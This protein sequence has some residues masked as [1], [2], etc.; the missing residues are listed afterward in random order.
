MSNL[1]NVE[2]ERH[3]FAS[4]I[5]NPEQWGEV[6]G[7]TTAQDFSSIHQ[8]IFNVF[9]LQLDQTPAKPIQPVI[10][11]DVIKQHSIPLDGITP[12]EYLQS[13]ELIPV[14][15]DSC[16]DFAKEIK[17]LSVR[18]D[19]IAKCDAVKSDLMRNKDKSVGDMLGLVEKELNDV[20]IKYVEQ[21]NQEIFSS[22]IEVIEEKGN[23]PQDLTTFGLMGP[24][25]S[26]NKTLGSLSYPSAF[27][28][29]G[30]R[31]GNGK[32]SLGFHYNTFVAEKYEI[33]VLHLDAGEMTVE[34][35]Q[36]R[37]TA[38]LSNGR[39]PLNMIETGTWRKNKEFVNIIRGE[40]WPRVKKIKTYYKNISGMTPKEFVSYIRRFYFSKIGRGNHLLIHW[41]YIKGLEAVAG[42]NSQEYQSIGYMVG[43][44]K[45]L[46]TTEITASVWTSV[47]NNKQG[48]YNG[49]DSSQVVDNE[50]SLSLSDRIL[51]QSTNAFTMRYKL[52]D[53][54]AKEGNLFGNVMLKSLKERKLLGENFQEMLDYVK[55]IE[56]DRD[57]KQSIKY[58]KNYFNLESKSFCYFDRG[59]LKDM[60]T[61][62]ARIP[63]AITNKRNYK[64]EPNTNSLQYHIDAPI[65]KCVVG[66]NLLGIKTG[67]SCCGFSYKGEEVEK[68][69]LAKSYIYI[70]NDLSPY[71]AKLLLDLAAM[72]QLTIDCIMGG[73][74]DFYGKTWHENH[75]WADLKCPHYYESFVL[76]INALEKA[77]EAKKHL[78]FDECIIKDGNSLYKDKFKIKYWQ[79]EPA[80]DWI[81]K[82][83]EWD[84]L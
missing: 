47:Q 81:L 52:P 42:K 58:K 7:F 23:N 38:S 68:K 44:L 53:E 74:I 29:V 10:L 28:T 36:M 43:D 25:D 49:L 55:V 27:V 26:I 22:L 69:H 83:E 1:H 16:E 37:A 72:S 17:R 35:L 32:S 75:P 39:V 59:S 80:E 73:W 70:I 60:M 3:F 14:A 21:D 79:Y 78:F 62:L 51:Q 57:N 64:M 40:V 48:I 71:N 9:K 77:L 13:I 76:A 67:M 11:A 6:A 50:N 5:K 41:D 84:S 82:K 66:L 34:D 4:L 12:Y 19:F 24:F 61:S 33:P 31:S 2:L 46:I 63:V 54:I 8:P 45:S 15:K 30:A 56:K 65:R 18:R 20:N